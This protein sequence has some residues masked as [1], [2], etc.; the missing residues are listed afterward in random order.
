MGIVFKQSAK[1]TIYVYTGLILGFITTGILFPRI[2]TTEQIGLLKIIVAYSSL[3]AIL[4]TLGINGATIRL[5]PWFRNEKRKHNGF[6]ALAMLTGLA[7]FILT[8]IL[9]I[10]LKPYMLS[11]NIQKSPLVASYF[12]YLIILV[13]FQ[14]F[15]SILDNYNTALYNSVQGTFLKEV[16]QRILIIIFI[17]LFFFDIIS[18]HQFVILYIVALCAPTVFIVFF[19][20]REKQFSLKPD[21]QFLNKNLKKSVVTVSLFSILNGFSLLAIQNIDVIMV[22][23]MIGLDYAGIYSI[24][25]FFG[26]VISMPARSISRITGIVSADAWKNNDLNTIKNIYNKSCMTLFIIG[27]LLFIGILANIDNIFK[28]IGPEYLPGK[29]VIFFI[30]LGNLIDMA[31]GANSSIFGTSIYYKVQ[32]FFLMLLVVLIVAANIILIPRFGIT[33]AAIGSAGALTLLNV[34]RYLF[35]YIKFGLQPY[36][37]KFLFVILIGG[38]SW[39]LTSLI[40]VMDNLIADIFIRC[41][42]IAILYFLPIYFSGISEDITE[43]TNDIIKWLKLKI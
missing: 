3:I 30:A 20:I 42:T 36:N 22:N 43:R 40:P 28:I 15:F 41:C 34:M 4:G 39:F 29:W 26:A 8:T 25:F 14:I 18:F 16:F 32:S 38:A 21:F 27:L 1:G 9:L 6:L 5:F 13:F 31:T 24:C 35:L 2:Y 17:G 12:N 23:S 33:G 19:L 7:G 10:V 37:K 11:T